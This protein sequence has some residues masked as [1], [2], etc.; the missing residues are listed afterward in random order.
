[1]AVRFEYEWHDARGQWYRAYD[2]EQWE[3]DDDGLMAKRFAS[4]NDDRSPNRSDVSP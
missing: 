3:S 2:N 1:M 4:I